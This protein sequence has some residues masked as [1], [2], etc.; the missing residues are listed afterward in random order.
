MVGTYRE[1]ATRILNEMRAEGLIELKRM[2]I[3][4][5]D[6]ERLEAIAEQSI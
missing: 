3:E 1:T 6:G 4:I 2:L 5:V